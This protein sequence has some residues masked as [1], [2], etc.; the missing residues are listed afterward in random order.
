MV[1]GEIGEHRDLKMRCVQPPL[2]DA[3][4]RGFQH[5]GGKAF[6]GEK[7]QL[8]LK[9]HRVWRRHSGGNHRTGRANPQ[10]SDQS[11]RALQP[12]KCLRQPPGGGCL[13]V[14]SG[15]GNDL[16]LL[17]G[18][19][20]IRC[21]NRS[22]GS[23]EAFVGRHPV[24]IEAVSLNARVL[25]QAGG[26]AGCQGGLDILT[27]I[28]GSPRPC[29]EAVALARLA[30][31]GP[32]RAGHALMQ[33]ARSLLRGV[34]LDGGQND[35]STVCVMICGITLTSGCTPIMRSVC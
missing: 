15:D 33:P 7:A 23:L 14:G 2:L 28:G 9:Q 17:A 30:A 29:D 18:R 24:I 26:R 12:A 25:D 5:A 32:Q 8:L 21:S 6:A 3:Y 19:A 31:I 4:R 16:K 27:A 13:A 35:S 10:R 22:G 34:K 1:L 20:E 11:A